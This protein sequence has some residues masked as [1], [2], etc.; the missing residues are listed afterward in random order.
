MNSE[1]FVWS[2]K[3]RALYCFAD[4]LRLC[5]QL[6]DAGARIIQLRA[7]QMGGPAFR[8]LAEEMQAMITAFPAPAIFVVNDRVDVAFGMGAD[9][10]HVG[11]E[12]AEYRQVIQDAPDGMTIGVSV[13]TAEQALD[14]QK[15]GATYVGAGSV[16]PTS[17]KSDASRMGL[18]ELKRIVA[19]TR[20]PVVAI[21]GI[22]LDNID[23]VINAGA[24]YY[25]M[26][27]QINQ[28]PDLKSRIQAFEQKLDR[29]PA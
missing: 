4:S 23:Q 29:G 6:L 19:A 13:D 17:T 16:F 28:A 7:K 10:L 3:K 18:A 25:A 12:D 20:I 8:Q 11:Q 15:A 22:G 21:G 5:R 27:S 24:H 14:A 26:I 9:G 1:A 2:R